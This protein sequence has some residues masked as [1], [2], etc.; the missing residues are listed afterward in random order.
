M[1][2]M[3]FIQFLRWSSFL[4]NA[5]FIGI[6]IK[7]RIIMEDYLSGKWEG[8]LTH[9]GKDTNA[10]TKCTMMISR[11]KER[12]NSG[13]IYYE[14]FIPDSRVVLYRGLDELNE[15]ETDFWFFINREWHPQFTRVFHQ[16]DGTLNFSKR[17]YNFIFN[18][19]DFIF[20]KRMKVIINVDDDFRLEGYFEKM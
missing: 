5:V 1:I 10:K 9:Y 13:Y 8:R 4:V 17:E 3:T 12:S 14:S 16:N 2:S 18:A 11:H 7:N 6:G 20:K 19:T 15:Y